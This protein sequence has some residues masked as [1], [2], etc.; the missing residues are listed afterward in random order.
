[1]TTFMDHLQT[2]LFLSYATNALLASVLAWSGRSFQGGWLWVLAQALLALGTLGDALPPEVPSWIPL[3][4]GNGA[5][6]AACLAYVHSVW[7]FRFSRPF[8]RWIYLVIPLE[9][10]SF[11]WAFPQPYL[12]KALVFSSWMTVGPLTAAAL[13]LWRLEPKFRLSN[14]LT[15]LPFLLL[16]SAS[17]LR[18]VLLAFVIP[19]GEVS[20]VGEVNVWF[21]A[22]AILL[23]TITLFGYFL[24]T[25]IRY[26]QSLHRK[27]SEIEDRNGRLLEAARSKDLFFA[28]VAHDLRGPI[29]GA[30]R[31]ARKHL[32]SKMSSDECRYEEV[33][34][35]TASLEK[36][37]EFLE[38]LLWW[39]RAQF[40]DWIPDR[41]ALDL[42]EVFAASLAMVAP[43]AEGKQIGFSVSPGLL[44]RP[45]GDAESVRLILGNL[46]S[47]AVKFSHP[48][49]A[50][51]LRVGVEG[52]R[53]L[54]TVEDEGVGMDADVLARLFR[55]ESK[56]TT[57]GTCDEPGNGLGLILVQSLAERNEGSV[58]MASEQGKGTRATLALPLATVS[59][60]YPF[61]RPENG[62]R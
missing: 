38:K 28:I 60:E 8:P 31:Y 29:G 49:G 48:G 41:I 55:M 27:D 46:L 51:R 47:N 30:A 14:G 1:M 39:S 13:L 19:P 15:A 58:S 45:L 53:C 6:I 22:G 3:V 43:L 40:R 34:T 21:V 62:L 2:I 17:L 50:V 25:G 18:V 54:I 16:G 57:N 4:L 37:N 20:P 35:L 24:M 32:V 10:L 5:Y 7:S 59:P 42:N 52:D 36:T 12:V 44:P 11:L 9:L 23:S 33:K 61:P 56:L 26:E